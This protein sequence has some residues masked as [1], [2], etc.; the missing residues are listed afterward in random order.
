MPSLG[1]WTYGESPYLNSSP[2]SPSLKESLCILEIA[3]IRNS[4]KQYSKGPGPHQHL[5]ATRIG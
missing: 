5:E 4:P 1:S 2:S 3:E